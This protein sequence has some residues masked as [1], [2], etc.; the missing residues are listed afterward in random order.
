K[1]EV[2]SALAWKATNTTGNVVE[3]FAKF[4]L[5]V[6]GV[7]HGEHDLRIGHTTSTTS[8]TYMQRNAMTRLSW[9]PVRNYIA[10]DYLLGRTLSLYRERADPTRFILEID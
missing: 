9:G 6:I 10:H 8:R 1:D 7:N 3:A 4:Q 2:F 5:V